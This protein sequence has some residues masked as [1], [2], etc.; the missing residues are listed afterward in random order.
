MIL[1]LLQ[2]FTLVRMIIDYRNEEESE[3]FIHRHMHNWRDFLYFHKEIVFIFAILIYKR[4]KDLVTSFSKLKYTGA[5]IS[6][7][8][9]IQDANDTLITGMNTT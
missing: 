1:N 6:P 4:R 9:Y 2:L 5:I 8:F 7:V 3:V